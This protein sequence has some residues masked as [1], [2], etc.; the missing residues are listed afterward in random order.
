MTDKESSFLDNSR[1]FSGDEIRSAFVNFFVKRGHKDI[2]SASLVPDDPTVLLTIAGM[3]PFKP[4]FLGK[5]NRPSPRAT[6]SQKCIRTNDIENVGRTARHHTFFEMLG[7]FSFGDYFKKEAIEWAW[8]LTTEVFGLDPSHLVISVYREDKEAERIWRDHIGVNPQR[9]I[10]MDEADNFWSSG[11]TGPCGPCSELYYDFNPELGNVQL[12]L[13]DDQRFIEFYNLVFM[14]YNRNS[15][16]ELIPLAN[17]NIDTGM[18][19][20]RMAQILQK[21]PNNY[22]TDL[23]YPLIE[24]AASFAHIDYRNIDDSK[25]TSLKILGDHSRAVTQLI[26]DG[27]TSSNLGRGYV[28][29]RLVRRMVRHGKLLGIDKPFLPSLGDAAINLMKRA[30]PELEES[31]DLILSE[32]KMEELRFLETLERGER[33]LSQILSEGSGDITGKQAFQLYDTYGFPLELTQEI[34]AEKNISID[35]NGFNDEMKKQR[36]R[37]K[38]AAV[39]IDLTLQGVLEKATSEFPATDFIGYTKL[40]CSSSILAL[41]IDGKGFDCAS[42]GDKVQV[43]LDKTP[44][45]AASGGQIGD[46][47]LLIGDQLVVEIEDVTREKQIFVH[48]GRI[49]QGTLRIHNSVTSKVDSFS[50][51]CAN[52]NHTATHLL[53]SALKL[54]IDSSV[55]QRGS[56]VAFDRLRFDFNS[57]FPIKASQLREMEVLINKW[58]IEDHPISIETMPIDRAL[59]AGAL[60]MFGEKYGDVVR[61]VDVPGVSMEL[62]GGTHVASTSELGIFKIVSEAGIA[63]GIRRIEAVAGPAVLDYVNERDQVVTDLSELLKSQ[64]NEIVQRVLSLQHELKLL[65][66]NLITIKKELAVAKVLSFRDQVIHIGRHQYIVQRVDNIDGTSLQEAAFDLT[67]R[68]GNNTAILLGGIPDSKD[69][70]KVILVASFG[71]EIVSLGLNAGKFVGVVA[72]LCG[73]GGGGRPNLA[74]AGGRK[75][76]ALN[77]AL[78]QAECDL[79]TQLEHY[80]S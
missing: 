47:G 10:C 49:K 34:A 50:R 1:P 15:K 73:G 44:F 74:Q 16:G 18:G 36:Q 76:E 40:Q 32:L 69:E 20:E 11:T 62:C 75:A 27:V 59:S 45:Y 58:I 79:R 57:P 41:F 21:V 80:S 29:R 70:K 61:V 68:L 60:A 35:I 33:L 38:D 54:T 46:K 53:Q 26:S 71:S 4:V 9:I 13:E 51:S 39:T 8:E 66:R 5:E 28:L 17:C 2:P 56:L 52:A 48:N 3:L 42:A 72:K 25:K 64:P 65:T 43:V 55:G 78:G 7:N 67:N 37:A 22:E 77:E 12:N 24:T 19:L 23:I 6:S 30:Y 63:S 31:R 14:Q